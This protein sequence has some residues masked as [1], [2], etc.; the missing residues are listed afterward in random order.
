MDTTTDGVST[1]FVFI[2]QLE[3]LILSHDQNERDNHHINGILSQSLQTLTVESIDDVNFSDASL[4]NPDN[5]KNSGFI[6][7]NHNEN[8]DNIKRSF[9]NGSR[10]LIRSFEWAAVENARMSMA[11]YEREADFIGRMV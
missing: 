11:L 6:N 2:S 9:S 3:S 10:D 8:I 4:Y 7:F 1:A 5:H